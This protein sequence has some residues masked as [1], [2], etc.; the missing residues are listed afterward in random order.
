[1]KTAAERLTL[2]GRAL[3]RILRVARTVADLQGASTVGEHHISEA[4]AF[5]GMDTGKQPLPF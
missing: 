5:R 2:S 4:L 1:L 3:H